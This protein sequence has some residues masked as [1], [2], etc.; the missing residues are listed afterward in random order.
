MCLLRKKK[1]VKTKTWAKQIYFVIGR[2][3]RW[4]RM[5]GFGDFDCLTR[6]KSAKL[7]DFGMMKQHTHTHIYITHRV[8]S[9]CAI[10]GKKLRCYQSEKTSDRKLSKNCLLYYCTLNLSLGYLF[11]FLLVCCVCCVRL[12][13]VVGPLSSS[14]SFFLFS[15]SSFSP[16]S[17]YRVLSFALFFYILYSFFTFLP[18][19]PS[20]WV[21]TTRHEPCNVHIFPEYMLK[22]HFTSLAWNRSSFS[23]V[24]SCTRSLARSFSLRWLLLPGLAIAWMNVFSRKCMRISRLLCVCFRAYAVRELDVKF[25]M[26]SNHALPRC[27]KWTCIICTIRFYMNVCVFA[28]RMNVCEMSMC[29]IK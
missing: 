15:S 28:K 17:L 1:D 22:I 26:R 4:M 27:I 10:A 7:Y 24:R 13:V 19:R 3:G 5:S 11:E 18:F 12:F 2:F 23:L 16:H 21:Q 25:S 6:E 20:K 9:K 29:H 14:L 8:R